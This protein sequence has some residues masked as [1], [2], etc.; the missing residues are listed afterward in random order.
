[1]AIYAVFVLALNVQWGYTGVFNFGVAAF[2]MVGAY[3]AAIFTMPPSDVEVR[4]STSVGSVTSFLLS[5]WTAK[6][7]CASVV[8]T[9]AAGLASGFLAFL[10][11]IP[12]LRLREDYL[13]IA[14]IGFAEV[15]RRVAI[16]ER[17]LVNGT[18]GLVGIPRPLAAGSIPATTS[19]SCLASA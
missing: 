13:A 3:T 4:A 10:L 16:E 7:G 14:T 15:L 9:A 11:S 8:G 19:T 1:M 6:N 18:N 12:T 2:F 5:S 17:G